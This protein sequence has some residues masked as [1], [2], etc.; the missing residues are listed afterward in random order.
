MRHSVLWEK[1]AEQT[2][3]RTRYFQE[4]FFE[5]SSCISS[6]LD[7]TKIIN[8]DICSSWL[9]A[10]LCQ[11]VH[12]TACTSFTKIIYN[13][14]FPS[15]SLEWFLRA[16]WYVVSCAIVLILTPTILNSQL[17]HCAVFSVNSHGDQ[18]KRSRAHFCP[19]PELYKEPEPW[20]Q[21]RP[22]VPIHL[23]WESR[24]IWVSLS[25]FSDPPYWLMIL[26]FIWWCVTGTWP[27]S[28]KILGVGSCL[29]DTRETPTQ[30][31]DIG[32]CSFVKGWVVQAEW[33][34]KRLILCFSSIWLP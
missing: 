24:R 23:L 21:Q 22:L 5:P 1:L 19:L 7:S 3:L 8:G 28:Y 6:Y 14:D 9:A 12:L 31:K 26:S 30:V 18:R 13:T 16:I 33:L 4:R 11:N 15:I 25:W 27:P 17:S 29:K 2:F 32:I 34:G 10:S 20:Y